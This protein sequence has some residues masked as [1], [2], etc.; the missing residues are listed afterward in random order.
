[1][2]ESEKIGVFVSYNH[3]D[4]SV[5]DEVVQALTS[6]SEQLRVFIDHSGLEGGDDYELKLSQSLQKTR[7]FII[8]CRGI[9]DMS[10][11]FY[12]AG[13]FRAKLAQENELEE[14]RSRMCYLYDGERRPSQ[15]A[16]YQGTIIR[17][18]LDIGSDD[19]HDYEN[20]GL[21]NLFETIIKRSQP[22]PLRDTT[23]QS[24]RRLMR[25]GVRRITRA[26]MNTSD[27]VGEIVFQ[28]RISFELPPPGEKSLLGLTPGTPVQGY[29]STLRDIFG[30]ADGETNWGEIKRSSVSADNREARW[31]GDVETATAE[32]SSK[33]LPT[34]TEALCIAR[35]GALFRPIVARY[36][37]YRN[38]AKKCHVAFIPE[39][40]RKFNLGMKT[41]LLL[42]GLILSVRFRQRILPII[43]EL[44]GLDLAA[45]PKTLELLLNFL[46]ELTTI[47]T[48]GLEFGISAP[49]DDRDEP[50][51]LN[52]FR[53]GLVKESLRAKI[54]AWTSARKLFFEKIVD[55]EKK[56]IS[57]S[58]AA[59]FLLD[60]LD[61]I[62][63]TNSIFIQRITE[64]LL[65]V[66]RIEAAVEDAQQKPTAA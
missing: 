55:A 33:K 64:E 43:D 4:R 30:I 60:C 8:I 28:P 11:C 47:E 29:E 2:T 56:A 41:S 26:F 48:E 38:E 16:R 10:W 53:E 22:N 3:R 32:I 9:K 12:E 66:Q 36:E 17:P 14:L 25:D 42:S 15:F 44:K 6:I 31:I 61:D 21:F 63:Q 59:R 62:H 51:L 23:D 49:A 37:K 45:S 50:A 13:Q 35:D 24:V 1:M 34:Q 54:L 20:T 65:H 46:K 58:D 5:A 40:N 52:A 18:L 7:W 19:S 39:R 27:V 57:P